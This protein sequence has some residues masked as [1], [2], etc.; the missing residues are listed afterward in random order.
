MAKMKIKRP[1][2]PKY[3]TGGDVL[4]GLSGIAN[5]IPGWGA[6]IGGG[7]DMVGG[8]INNQD[9]MQEEAA[10]A[11]NNSKKTQQSL[12]KRDHLSSALGSDMYANGGS[13][14]TKMNAPT[15]ADG[16]AMVDGNGNPTSQGVA[17]VEKDETIL[18]GKN[19]N[20]AFSPNLI[21]PLTG[22][23][24]AKASKG[25]E[26][27]LK[28]QLNDGNDIANRT[29]KSEFKRLQKGNET[30]K[31]QIDQ[32]TAS[33][34]SKLSEEVQMANGG[35]FGDPIRTIASHTTDANSDLS[36]TFYTDKINSQ[37]EF[38]N[39]NKHL[40]MA[41]MSKEDLAR[42]IQD[43]HEVRKSIEALNNPQPEPRLPNQLDFMKKNVKSATKADTDAYLKTAN[44]PIMTKANGGRIKKY[45]D[46]GGLPKLD[47]GGDLFPMPKFDFNPTMGLPGN[48]GSQLFNAGVEG[49]NLNNKLGDYTPTFGFEEA[50]NM[51]QGDAKGLQTKMKDYL[52]KTGDAYKM[53]KVD[54]DLGKMSKG[55]FDD[56]NRVTGFAKSLGL[57][58]PAQG[59][60]PGATPGYYSPRNY[61]RLISRKDEVSPLNT[62]YE[63]QINDIYKKGNIA[64]LTTPN[65]SPVI[66]T[67]DQ[68][69]KTVIKP[70]PNFGKVQP[71][72]APTPVVNTGKNMK[73]EIAADEVG[74]GV[75]AFGKGVGKFAK[76]VY[77]GK[78]DRA[79]GLTAKAGEMIASGIAAFRNPDQIPLHLNPN[80]AEAEDVA[81]S[82]GIS[83]NQARQSARESLNSNR[84][85]SQ[86]AMSNAVK[87]AL[88]QG[89]QNSYVEQMGSIATQE[90]AAR[91]QQNAN[92][93]NLLNQLGVQDMSARNLQEQLQSQTNAVS[94]DAKKTF[95][96]SVGNMGEFF[97]NKDVEKRKSNEHFKLLKNRYPNFNMAVETQSQYNTMLEDENTSAADLFVFAKQQGISDKTIKEHIKKYGSK[98]LQSQVIE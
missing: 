89:A 98:N 41:E 92:V 81:R 74:A 94:A 47:N 17:E 64:N 46:G 55:F 59:E 54:G 69:G 85:N 16:G 35:S 4:S 50:K 12:A 90:K 86:N 45:A 23:T 10:V 77:D 56:Q 26:S 20:F 83:Y 11:L 63:T 58:T 96:E 44:I 24:F 93:S 60:F 78:F 2:V 68:N 42:K 53:G 73:G 48:M 22:K 97:L 19:Q 9:K 38:E 87:L 25:V 34:Q 21:D 36:N 1:S 18:K 3:G 37:A 39:A 5:M 30:Q 43:E 95:A 70:N 80:A 57:K 72:D 82:S 8:I 75:T 40:T 33:I 76:G 62:A 84:V 13:F 15:H 71:V 51:Y 79:I 7:L 27:K 14:L 49:A 88:N 52:A 31:Q 91:N 61:N 6:L 32:L 65:E 66:T 29:R 28:S 67:I